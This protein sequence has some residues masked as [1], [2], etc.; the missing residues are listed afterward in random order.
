[1]F[2]NIKMTFVVSVFLP[3]ADIQTTE[4]FR[5]SDGPSILVGILNDSS[6]NL[7]ILNSGFTVVA[8]AATG[9]EILKEAFMELKIDELILQLLKRQSKGSVQSLYDAIRVLLTP[10]D[11]RVVAS[12]VSQQISQTVPE[13][14]LCHL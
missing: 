4:T 14:C 2:Y 8:A 6:Q 11:N 7:D 13:F 12:Q 9:N 3:I 10:D 5:N 1:M